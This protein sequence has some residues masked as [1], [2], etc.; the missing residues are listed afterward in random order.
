ML[1]A[2]IWRSPP[3]WFGNVWCG[4]VSSWRREPLSG[5]GPDIV[6][7]MLRMSPLGSVMSA[8]SFLPLLE[9]AMPSRPSSPPLETLKRT[10]GALAW[11]LVT[12]TMEPVCCATYMRVVS[13]PRN[14]IATGLVRPVA[15]GFSATFAA[16]RLMGAAAGLAAAFAPAG[17]NTSAASTTTPRTPPSFR[18]GGDYEGGRLSS[19][20]YGDPV[21]RADEECT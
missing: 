10:R 5:L 7:S 13:L 14:A 2:P 6:N 1:S 16:V 3:L 21:R 8:Y 17:T 15:T 19:S 12:E 4:I 11:P 20:G 18:I 9:N